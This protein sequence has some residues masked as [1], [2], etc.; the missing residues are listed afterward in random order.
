MHLPAI[1]NP[2]SACHRLEDHEELGSGV[3][4]LEAWDQRLGAAARESK[5]NGGDVGG[6]GARQRAF[7]TNVCICNTLIVERGPDGEY[8]Y[9]VGNSQHAVQAQP[10]GPKSAALSVSGTSSWCGAATMDPA[11]G[12]ML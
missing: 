7:W 11:G 6:L 4:A 12:G 1:P 8:V 3:G 10:A 2:E 9:Q 5:D